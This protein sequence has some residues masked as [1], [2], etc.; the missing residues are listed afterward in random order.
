[1]EQVLI[2]KRLDADT[3]KAIEETSRQTFPTTTF[4]ERILT[5]KEAEIYVCVKLCIELWNENGRSVI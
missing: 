1:M 2:V 5:R 3:Q 4:T